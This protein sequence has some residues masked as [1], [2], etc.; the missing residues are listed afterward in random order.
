[1]K[2]A[3]DAYTDWILANKPERFHKA[4]KAW[5]AWALKSGSRTDLH[6]IGQRVARDI[7]RRP[8][9]EGAEKE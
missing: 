2:D 1:M 8:L 4:P 5:Q 7:A 9:A 6:T 3:R